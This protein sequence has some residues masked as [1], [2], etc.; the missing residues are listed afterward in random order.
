MDPSI[1]G[2][3]VPILA[4]VISA[5]IGAAIG[6]LAVLFVAKQLDISRVG[7]TSGELTAIDELLVQ[8]P[9]FRACFYDGM[10]PEDIE[11]ITDEDREVV[12]AIAARLVNGYATILLQSR[13]KPESSE[14]NVA[15][16]NATVAR[17]YG[18]SMPCCDHLVSYI[19]EYGVTGKHQ[20]RLMLQGLND[21]LATARLQKDQK[22][23]ERLTA[24]IKIAETARESLVSRLDASTEKYGG[25]QN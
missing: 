13:G 1:S 12:K 11:G 17:R 2:V 4:A 24:R 7:V 8:H 25:K 18:N 5:A 9:Q 6:V 21:A 19:E 10:D 22:K 16:A 3:V 23:V 20:L 15:W 14:F